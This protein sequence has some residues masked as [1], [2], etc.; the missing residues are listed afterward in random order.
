MA[1]GRKTGGR[2]FTKGDKRINRKGQLLSKEAKALRRL[3]TDEYIKTI[4]KFMYMD[5]TD[6]Q[7]IFDTSHPEYDRKITNQMPV[8]EIFVCSVLAK[9]IK[10]GDPARMEF[11]LNR[12]L[13]KPA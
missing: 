9:C 11:I 7:K 5:L 4:N 6:L 3:T 2:N 8:L 13:G 10:E 12:I 1:P